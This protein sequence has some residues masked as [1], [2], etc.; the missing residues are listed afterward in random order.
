M[1]KKRN[2]WPLL[3][4]TLVTFLIFAK[5]FIKGLVP[6]PGDLLVS[7]YFPW[8]SG[9]WEGYDQWTTHKASIGD[10]SL[11][12]QLPWVRVGFD[13]IKKG[14]IPLWNPFNFSGTPLLANIQSFIFYPL[15]F[16][17]LIMPLIDAWSL[18]IIL[19]FFLGMLFF[20]LFLKKVGIN[21]YAALLASMA[22]IFSSFFLFNSLINI[23]DHSLIWTPLILYAFESL[24]EK[25]KARYLILSTFAFVAILLGGNTQSAVYAL[26]VALGYPLIVDR[27]K[28]ILIYISFVIAILLASFQI[29]PMLELYFNSPLG[30]HH[31]QFDK[32]LV[33][34]K[35]LVTFLAPDFYGNVVTNNFR[36]NVFGDGTPN[37][38]IIPVI[39]AIYAFFNL[40]DIRAKF[41][42]AATVLSLLFIMPSPLSAFIK[43]A[44]IPVLSGSP[45]SRAAFITT[46]SLVFLAAYGLDHFLKS[47]NPKSI[48]KFVFIFIFLYVA[49]TLFVLFSIKT[50]SDATKIANFKTSLRNLVIPLFIFGLFFA[51]SILYIK[52]KVQ[53]VFLILCLAITLLPF[54]YTSN[55]VLPFSKKQFIFPQHPV[56]DFLKKDSELPRFYGIDTS[57]FATNLASYYGIYSPE[58]YGVLRLK[59]Y[60]EL[61]AA[62]KEGKIP[63]R[64]ERA[65]AIFPSIENGH[66]KRVFDLLGVKY[67]LDKNDLEDKEWNPQPERFPSDGVEL[68]WQKGIFKIY[69]RLDALPRYFQTT[70]FNIENDGEII[71]K[72]YDEKFNLKILLL[73]DSPN[74]PIEREAKFTMPQLIEY[75]PNLIEFRTATDYSSLLFLSDAY[76]EG[77]NA[78]IDNNKVPILRTDYAFRSVAVPEGDHKVVFKYQPIFFRIG[79][80][81][82]L[83]SF[84]FLLFYIKIQ[85]SKNKF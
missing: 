6:I 25:F 26:I 2:L 68:I 48:L 81:I 73:E 74:I 12:Q 75:S 28:S 52:T 62:A 34:Y 43:I 78:Y 83:L 85:H 82:S 35:N 37:I 65:D 32:F 71:R 72:I 69:K 42:A 23:I 51:V 47:K 10:D 24:R 15:N 21:T 59:R 27:K 50:G 45:P 31:P 54:L 3:A 49:I 29:L 70:S 76:E 18:L 66:R 17:F 44:P 4:I 80:L 64:Y 53:K 33:P 67:F 60:A 9:G 61:I 13:E 55:K 77:W 22:F 19:Q 14:H 39:F 41:F 16:V 11:R 56:I 5:F 30:I 1:K 7:F 38:G 57:A 79:A 20:Y 84:M 8:N 58:G 36:S 40:K 63:Q 46:F